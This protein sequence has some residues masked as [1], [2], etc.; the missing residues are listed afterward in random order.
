MVAPLTPGAPLCRATAPGSPVD[1][2]EIVFDVT[3]P[4]TQPQIYTASRSTIFEAWQD[5]HPVDVVNL[6]DKMQTRASISRDGTRL[7]FGSNRANVAGDSG[8]DIFVSTRS[9]PGK[10]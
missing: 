3:A 1:G 4:G 2:L 6:P 7:Y 8:T 9:G 5:V 10:R